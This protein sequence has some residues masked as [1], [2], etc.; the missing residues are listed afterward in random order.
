MSGSGIGHPKGQAVPPRNRNTSIASMLGASAHPRLNALKRKNA[1]NSTG[2]RPTFSLAGPQ[3][4]GPGDPGRS[5]KDPVS[6]PT[7]LTENVT[8]HEDSV[9]NNNQRGVHST[10]SR[11]ARDDGRHCKRLR[12]V[13]GLR[14]SSNPRRSRRRDRRR[15]HRG[16]RQEREAPATPRVSAH[17]RHFRRTAHHLRRRDQFLGFSISPG[18]SNATGGVVF[19]TPTPSVSVSDVEAALTSV[20][21]GRAFSESTS[22]DDVDRMLRPPVRGQIRNLGRKMDK[23]RTRSAQS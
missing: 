2:R 1:T 7:A 12:A 23:H 18:P 22:R 10:R 9:S 4:R 8:R 15:N 6:R 19:D 5:V 21:A 3:T 17:S 20:A 14:L 13:M 16:S 11:V